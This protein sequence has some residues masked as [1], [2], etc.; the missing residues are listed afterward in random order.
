MLKKANLAKR[1]NYI[2]VF[3]SRAS[4]TSGT[5]CGF[6]QIK[7]NIEKASDLGQTEWAYNCEFVGNDIDRVS[8]TANICGGECERKANCN[9]FTW[10]GIDQVNK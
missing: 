5:Q 3:E 9:H 8:G 4:E 2:D 6:L 10:K 7:W 1:S